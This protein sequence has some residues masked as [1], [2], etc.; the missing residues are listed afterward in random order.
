MKPETLSEEMYRRAYE[1]EHW[2]EIQ[3]SARRLKEKADEICTHGYVVKSTNDVPIGNLFLEV[4]D[5]CQDF[6]YAFVKIKGEKHILIP[7]NTKN[8]R[9]WWKKSKT[10]REPSEIGCRIVV[11]T[12]E[13]YCLKYFGTKPKPVNFR[14]I[15]NKMLYEDIENK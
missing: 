3:E 9:I 14:V 6:L 7:D 5:S 15:I 1:S 2:R 13:E 10:W 12:D 8:G 4:Y 11:L